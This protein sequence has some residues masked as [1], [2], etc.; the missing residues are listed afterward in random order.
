MVTADVQPTS[1]SP[2]SPAGAVSL[3]RLEMVLG[4]LL[5]ISLTLVAIWSLS[6]GKPE[7]AVVVAALPFVVYATIVRPNVALY[8]VLFLIY[9]NAPVILMR[10][11]GVPYIISAAIPAG[12]LIPIGYYVFVRRESIFFPGITWLVVGF[13]VVQILGT[14]FAQEPATAFDGIV[15]SVTEGVALYLLIVNAVRTRQALRGAAYA[16]LAAGT[17]MGA[18]GAH[19]YATGS[20]HKNY[21]GFAQIVGKGF[22]VERGHGTVRQH[23][24]TG[25]IGVENRYAQIMLML[26]PVG[27]YCYWGE[28]SLAWRATALA[29]TATTGIGWALAFSRGSAVGLVLTVGVMTMMGCLKVRQVFLVGIAS[30]LLLVVVPE[31]RTRLATLDVLPAFF[32]GKMTSA[33][34]PDGAITGRLT[35]MMAAAKVFADHPVIGVGPG[36]FRYYARTYAQQGGLKALD[37][38][39][40][41]HCLYVALL[42]EFGILGTACFF[43]AVGLTMRDLYRLR[44][45]CLREDTQAAALVT[46]FFLMIVVYLLTGIFEHFSFIRY[47]WTMMALSTAAVY[48]T[49]RHLESLKSD[50]DFEL[51]GT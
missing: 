2:P 46:G 31:Y 15:I 37:G 28:T 29:G 47:F 24:A 43:G 6:Q 19:Q 38:Q 44:S 1:P 26:I 22:G 17:F 18:L 9:T 7:I 49:Q 34:A 13:V 30:A 21:G 42:A 3:G 27:L 4:A 35:E 40:E 5:A 33:K 16:L 11:H 51:Q 41:A 25:P 14:L 20:Y 48:V 10:H 50:S 8:V 36:M 12:L 45:R 39:R 32:S 23:R